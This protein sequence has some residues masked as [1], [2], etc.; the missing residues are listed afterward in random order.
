MPEGEEFVCLLR[1]L[2]KRIL[3]RAR[4]IE[5][6]VVMGEERQK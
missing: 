6:R 5:I 1:E 2:L 3:N 4:E